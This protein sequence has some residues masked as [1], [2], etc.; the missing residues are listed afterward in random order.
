MEEYASGLQQMM[1]NISTVDWRQE[2]LDTGV[3]ED[4]YEACPADAARSLELQHGQQY[5][6]LD[7]QNSAHPGTI[8]FI[9]EQAVVLQLHSAWVTGEP[10]LLLVVPTQV[11]DPMD[12]RTK[13]PRA[14]PSRRKS[15]AQ[16]LTHHSLLG[17]PRVDANTS[18][19]NSSFTNGPQQPPSLLTGRSKT[20]FPLGPDAQMKH[21]NKW[22]AKAKVL[23][24]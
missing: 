12:A 20:V 15:P 11:L 7:L 21:V 16:N 2:C 9:S 3:T 14:S 22:V 1:A 13:P 4:A 10:L 17:S 6:V 18:R 8:H 19:R 23:G 5:Q 24:C